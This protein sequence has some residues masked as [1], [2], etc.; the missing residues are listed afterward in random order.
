[1][2]QSGETKIPF[3]WESTKLFVNSCPS[4]Y[5]IFKS[6]PR[7]V[8]RGEGTGVGTGMGTRVGSEVGWLAVGR[9]VAVGDGVRPPH[10]T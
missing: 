9:L 3:G 6:Q 4:R 2:F 10:V 7:L 1:M 8:G 5:V